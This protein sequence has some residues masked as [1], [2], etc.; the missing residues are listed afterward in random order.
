MVYL[1]MLVSALALVFIALIAFLAGHFGIGAAMIALLLIYVVVLC[2]CFKQ[3][4]DATIILLRL[5]AQFLSTNCSVYLTPVGVGLVGILMAIF[6]LSSING[7]SLHVA[8]DK[9]SESAAG[10]LTALHLLFYFFFMY[11]LYYVMVFLIAT[12]AGDWYFQ[13]QG[14]CWSGV[15]RLVR[16]HIGSLTFASSVITIVK[17]V[18]AAVDTASRNTENACSAICL[19]MVK[20][21]LNI[22]EGL[23]HTLNHFA[24]IVMTYTG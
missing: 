10:G 2:C 13:R 3:N 9:L 4:I 8:A 15:K 20:C 23:V 22:L 24:I 1:T 14:G 18:Q 5:T 11:F 21:F 16:G 19:C 6:A 12:A 17:V 7:I